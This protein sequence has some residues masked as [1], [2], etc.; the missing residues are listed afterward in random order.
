MLQVQVNDQRKLPWNDLERLST[1]TNM[2]AWNKKWKMN[3]K[4]ELL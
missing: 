2:F 1:K 3:Q 4:T